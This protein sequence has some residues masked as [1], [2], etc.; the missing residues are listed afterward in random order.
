MKA[1]ANN[2]LSQQ[3][4]TQY[5]ADFPSLSS[6]ISDFELTLTLIINADLLSVHKTRI[7]SNLSE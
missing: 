2:L 6:T 3:Q 1:L 5:I 4:I 7:D